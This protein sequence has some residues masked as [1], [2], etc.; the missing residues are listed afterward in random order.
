MS[1]PV[2][3]V[4]STLASRPFL[5]EEG[6]A[7]GL[8][9]KQLRGRQFSRPFAGVRTTDASSGVTALATAYA[10]KM[11]PDEFF[12]HT[13]AAVLH[14]IWLPLDH[15]KEEML[16]V[17][18][19]PPARA[20]RDRRVKGHHL[21]E[22]PGLVQERNGLRLANPIETWCQLAT[23]LGLVDLV[24][25]GESLLA[26]GR[27]WRFPLHLLVSAVEVGDR[28]RQGLLERTL[29][30]LREGV[31]SPQE[32]VLRLLIV[33]AG[34]PEPEINGVIT[35]ADGVFVAECD[36]VYRRERVLIEYEGEGHFERRAAR[37]DI[38][39]YERLQ[40]LGWRVIRVTVDDLRD[41][42]EETI[43]RIR[44][45]LASR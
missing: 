8:S 45:A 30:L 10:P 4:P 18:V 43:Q 19:R 15:E 37:K 41:H 42:P 13:T 16:H 6:L 20:P 24:I 44:R 29:P 2:D 17:S 38:T 26:K 33:G 12:S 40:D 34:L 3:P 27:G 9:P 14:G 25:A 7:A 23:I 22:R 32:T 31:R 39:R 36:L 35:A 11:T 1:R 28:P 21:V 5:L